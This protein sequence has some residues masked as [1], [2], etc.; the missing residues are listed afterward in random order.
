M[1]RNTEELENR[2]RLGKNCAVLRFQGLQRDG[3]HLL[4]VLP[5]AL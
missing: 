5:G 3:I 4:E 1:A 2:Q